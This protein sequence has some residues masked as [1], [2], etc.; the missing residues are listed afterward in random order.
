MAPLVATADARISR[1]DPHAL[2]PTS[3]AGGIK[4]M[5]ELTCAECRHPILDKRG[6]YLM[7]NRAYHPDCY[8]AMRVRQRGEQIL[9]VDSEAGSRGLLAA[10]LRSE[11]YPVRE[12]CNPEDA[13]R[14][15]A[16]VRA[17]L[18]LIDLRLPGAAALMLIRRLRQDS[19]T[20]DMPIIAVGVAGVTDDDMQAALVA[21]ASACCVEAIGSPGFKALISI[22][23]HDKRLAVPRPP[24]HGPR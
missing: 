19:A 5:S 16:E 24:S 9:V 10:V 6:H 14:L 23:L 21:G 13:V 8:D 17:N 3:R 12:A 2:P 11:G 1:G 4:S 20:R 15:L 22:F 18:V 7:V